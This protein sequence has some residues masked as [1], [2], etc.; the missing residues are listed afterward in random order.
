LKAQSNKK[1][2]SEQSKRDKAAKG[3]A[4][5]VTA[6]RAKNVTMEILKVARKKIVPPTQSATTTPMN[7]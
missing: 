4:V 5:D 7:K 1:N 3:C 2:T 6:S